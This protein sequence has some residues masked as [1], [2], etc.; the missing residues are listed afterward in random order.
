MIKLVISDLD[1]TLLTHANGQSYIT[2]EDLRAISKLQKQDIKLIIASGRILGFTQ[3]LLA[4]YQLS[5]DLIGANGASAYVDD[6]IILSHHIAKDK[7]LL[8]YEYLVNK[9]SRILI[10]AGGDDS[11]EYIYDSLSQKNSRDTSMR[12]SLKDALLNSTIAINKIL[13]SNNDPLTFDQL[14]DDIKANFSDHFDIHQSGKVLIDITAKGVDKGKTVREII[15]HLG[16]RKEQVAAIGDSPNDISMFNEANVSF[17]MLNGHPEV[18]EEADYAV[19]SF[20][21]AVDMIIKKDI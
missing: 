9:Y 21:E 17:A 11:V 6:K 14:I 8:M 7:A 4:Q 5:F 1:N 13:I 16:Y 12:I 15:E 18:V 10:N 3:K 2:E 20:A 19:E